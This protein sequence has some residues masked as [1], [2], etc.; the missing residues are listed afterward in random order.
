M[1][2]LDTWGLLLIHGLP[3][4]G[5]Y[6]QQLQAFERLAQLTTLQA[7]LF[8][9]TAAF[10]KMAVMR[11]L[12]RGTFG[13]EAA[14]EFDRWLQIWLARP[15]TPE[16]IVIVAYSLGGFLFYNWVADKELFPRLQQRL[17]AAI[18]IAAPYQFSTNSVAVPMEGGEFTSIKNIPTQRVDPQLI[19]RRLSRKLFIVTADNDPQILSTDSDM[20]H[21]AVFAGVPSLRQVT[22][23]VIRPANAVGRWNPHW[24]VR[25]DGEVMLTVSADLARHIA[26]HLVRASQHRA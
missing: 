6:R 4:Q 15:N 7:E 9:W 3:E 25:T 17:M 21:D 13:H 5:Q 23:P 19:K 1:A 20:A 22:F 2:R 18:T 10:D 24:E 12:R 16:R 11:Y 14:Q 8:D 26:P